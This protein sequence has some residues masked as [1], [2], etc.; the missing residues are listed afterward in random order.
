METHRGRGGD[1]IRR[2]RSHADA[3][4]LEGKRLAAGGRFHVRESRFLRCPKPHGRRPQA[5][6]HPR[7]RRCPFQRRRKSTRSPRCCRRR[8]AARAVPYRPRRLEC[9]GEG[10]RVSKTGAGCREVCPRIHARP[11]RRALSRNRPDAPGGQ[12]PRPVRKRSTR[13]NA[14]VVAECIENQGHYLPLIEHELD[15]ILGEESWV[16]PSHS[17]AAYLPD[18]MNGI[19]LAV[20][21]RGWTVATTDYWLGDKLRPATRERIRAELK[22][23]V[24]DRYEAAVRGWHRALVVDGRGE[25]LGRGLQRRCHR[26]GAG[27]PPI[28]AGARALH[29][30]RPQQHALLPPKL[31]RQRLLP[32]G[33]HLLEITGSAI[34]SASPK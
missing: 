19:D 28:A 2:Q 34:T 7:K 10:A 3:L 25:Q 33:H 11:Y 5:L 4:S 30:R 8:R 9:G 26:C 21:A 32:R 24:F 31:L 22:R 18:G 6:I 20:A 14:F 1:S 17:L 15:A 12:L 13:L 16:S 23:R 27:H 29:L